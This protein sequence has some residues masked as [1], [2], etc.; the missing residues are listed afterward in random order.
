MEDSGNGYVPRVRVRVHRRECVRGRDCSAFSA[1]HTLR[2]TH[3]H[4]PGSDPDRGP[5]RACAVERERPEPSHRPLV[6]PSGLS[7]PAML[8]SLCVSFAGGC[9]SFTLSLCHRSLRLFQ[10][11]LSLSQVAV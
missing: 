2:D 5:S 3:T 6:S 1:P 4:T 9:V 11:C 7:Q 10:L 8:L